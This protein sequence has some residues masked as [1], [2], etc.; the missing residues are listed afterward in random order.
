[1]VRLGQKSQKWLKCLHVLCACLWVGGAMTLFSM[2]VFL[3]P[4]DGAGLYG[5]NYSKKFVD[6]F[7]VVPGAVGLL[8]T[9]VAY[10]ILTSWGWFKHRWITLKWMVNLFGVILGTFWLGPWTDSLPIISR[11]EGIKSLSNPLYL[12]NLA[13]LR[14]W[15]G[16]LLATILFALFIS[17]MKPWKR[18][19]R[20]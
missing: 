6:D 17:I 8:F 20:A 4:G 14:G 16:F 7:I 18:S 5:I 1:M 15:G 13:M 11:S 19:S 9:G 3:Q 2:N 12:H 10:S